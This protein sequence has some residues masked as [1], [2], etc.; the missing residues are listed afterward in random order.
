MVAYGQTLTALWDPNPVSDDVTSYEVCVGTTSLSCNTQRATVAATENSYTFAV[1]AGVL[2][3]VAVRAA[4]AA[5]WGQYSPEVRVSIPSLSQPPNQTSTVNVPISP[6]TLTASDPDGGALQFSHTGLPL[7]LNLNTSTGVI[8]GTPTTIGS[9]TVTVFVTDSF[10]TTSRS[11][12]WTVQPPSTPDN[13]APTLAITSHVA[14]QTVTTLSITLS[15]SATDSGSGGSGIS[16]VTVNG[17]AATGGTA[18]GSIAANWSRN[19]SLVMGANTITVEARDGANN[20]S[21]SQITINRAVAP[22]T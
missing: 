7:G 14:G 9:F 16:S 22:V 21:A 6:V 17:A 12:G 5:G 10:E 18:T 19:V 20:L 2:Y 1:Q 4:S 11:F 3:Y 8:S 15:G 13:T